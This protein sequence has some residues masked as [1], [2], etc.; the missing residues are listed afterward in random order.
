FLQLGVG[1]LEAARPETVDPRRALGA[2]A[3]AGRT[4]VAAIMAAP[5]TSGAMRPAGNALM[6]CLPCMWFQDPFSRHH[7][8]AMRRS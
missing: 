8:A 1:P 4:S 2:Q 3:P 7:Q 5:A 6:T